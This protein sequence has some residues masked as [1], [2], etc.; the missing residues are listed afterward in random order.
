MMRTAATPGLGRGLR[1]K[2]PVKILTSPLRSHSTYLIV[3][4]T[5]SPA[6]G[7]GLLR[8]KRLEG[9]SRTGLEVVENEAV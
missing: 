3:R 6:A 5:R 8:R 1:S 2:D 9:A 4:Q 7:W